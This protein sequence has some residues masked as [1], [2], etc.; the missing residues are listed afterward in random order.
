M[1]PVNGFRT[2]IGLW[3][4][5][6]IIHF[7]FLEYG[8]GNE[9]SIYGDVYSYGIL[10]LEMFSGK[11]PTDSKFG[12]S[13]GLH[14]YVNMALPDRVASV[15]DLSLLEET[16]DGEARTSI[17]NQTREMRIAC[18]TS[19]LHVGVSCSVETPTDRVPI[20]DALKELQRIRE[21]PQGVARS[22]SDNPSRHSN[23]LMR[24]NQPCQ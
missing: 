9:V 18:I 13:L 6:L 2:Y 16:E 3:S 19:I 24:S 12:E 23:L 7:L 22:R 11:R 15:I 21:V 20:G 4:Y 1:Y 10:L 17:S 5:F 8:L 14:K